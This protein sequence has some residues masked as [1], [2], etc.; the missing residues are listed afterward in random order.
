MASCA[1]ALR[2]LEARGLT[3]VAT[4]TTSVAGK[5]FQ[6]RDLAVANVT[7][8]DERTVWSQ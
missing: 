3:R 5:N 1:Q 7:F 2:S 6:V 8:G 4:R